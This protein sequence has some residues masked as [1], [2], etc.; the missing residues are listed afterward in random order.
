LAAIALETQMEA[1]VK[2]E[3]EEGEGL[4]VADFIKMTPFN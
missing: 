2:E 3:G 4:V 1:E